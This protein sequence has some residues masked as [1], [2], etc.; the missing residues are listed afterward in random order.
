MNDLQKVIDPADVKG[1]KNRYINVLQHIA[2][3]DAL[4]NTS[5]LMALDVGCGIER[6]RGLFNGYYGVDSDP[7]M[8]PAILAECNDLPSFMTG[9]IDI[10]LSVWMLQYQDDLEECMDEIRRVLV[11]GGRLVMIEQ[12]SKEGYA[13]V[14]PRSIFNYSIAFGKE[15]ERC[16]PILKE[17]D[18][19][20]GVIRRGWVPERLFPVLARLHLMLI[21]YTKEGVYTDYLMVFRK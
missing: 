16:V 18:L 1:H 9:R 20:V 3:T 4:G 13:T 6:F 14:L 8:H 11:P 5:E 19:L 12:I 15:P 7:Q 10:V 17:G 2:L 21:K